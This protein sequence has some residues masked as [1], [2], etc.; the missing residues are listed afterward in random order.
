MKTNPQFP[1]STIEPGGAFF[2]P[3]LRPDKTRYDGL[4][5]AQRLDIKAKAEIGAY[6]GFYG[7][8][9]QRV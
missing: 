4:V 1:W 5:E 7:V 9:F 6:K 8:K 2:V 3:S